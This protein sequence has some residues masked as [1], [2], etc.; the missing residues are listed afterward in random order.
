[1]PNQPAA[2]NAGIA[3]QLLIGHHWPGVGEPGRSAFMKINALVL[4]ILVFTCGPGRSQ[5]AD[6]QRKVVFVDF[7]LRDGPERAGSLIISEQ[8]TSITVQVPVEGRLQAP[9]GAV[10]TRTPPDVAKLGLQV[11]LLKADGTVVSQQRAGRDPMM[12]SG[13]GIENWFVM[14]DFAKVP[15]SEITGIVFLRE[16]KLYSQQL[17]ATDWKP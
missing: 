14:F 13:A 15:L 5:S 4:L 10:D 3:S 7:N 2:P 1:M 12:I 8:K 11:W 16:G 17:A 6:D 9:R